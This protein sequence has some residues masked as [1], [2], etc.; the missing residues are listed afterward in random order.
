MGTRCLAMSVAVLIA[1]LSARAAEPL[2]LALVIGNGSYQALPPLPSCL[3]SARVVA[4][5]LQRAG[6]TVREQT[7]ESNG[8]LGTAISDFADALAAAPG[9]AAV[10]YF[11]GY[12]VGFNGRV[13]LLPTPATLERS[14]DALTQGVVGRL[15]VQAVTGA[16]VR[17]GLILLDTV[18]PPGA[19]AP[20]PFATLLDGTGLDSTGVVAVQSVGSAPQGSTTLAVALSAAFAQQP[21]ELKA[22]VQ[23]LRNAFVGQPST[24]LVVHEPPSPRLLAGEAAPVQAAA[25][26]P[27]PTPSQPSPSQP[28][29][30]SMPVPS[31]TPVP[32]Q[33]TIAAPWS[34]GPGE[35]RR[36]QLALQRLGY[37]RGM[38]DG[39]AGPIMLA[40]IKRYQTENKQE[41]TG[42]LTEDEFAQLLQVGR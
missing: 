40:A 14:T 10:L 31:S 39:V 11:C 21:V 35:L 30:S 28:V 22:T 5:T 23:T 7:N 4:A 16:P 37:F 38:I 26:T 33:A 17:A 6:F 9:A 29:A 8:R 2:K 19:T 41:P 34:P 12:A 25:P 18:A 24:T 42:L 13:F 15:P 32:A 1:P 27:T 3:S 20:T 36:G